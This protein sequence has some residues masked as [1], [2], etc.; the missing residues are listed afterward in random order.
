VGTDAKTVGAIQRII[1]HLVVGITPAWI[2]QDERHQEAGEPERNQADSRAK[3]AQ[4][5]GRFEQSGENVMNIPNDPQKLPVSVLDLEARSFSCFR[6]Y[7]IKTLG[8]LVKFS[9]RELL[10]CRNFGKKSAALVVSELAK[11]SLVLRP[12]GPPRSLYLS[13]QDNIRIQCGF[14]LEQAKILDVDVSDLTALYG[15][16][17]GGKINSGG[18]Q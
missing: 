4:L 6:R 9:R 11:F 7:D 3:P 5:L 15:K 16:N 13:A 10:E 18:G 8:D 17:T 12:N 2:H 14:W 1:S